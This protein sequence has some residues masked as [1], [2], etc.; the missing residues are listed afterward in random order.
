MGKDRR[1]FHTEL[2]EDFLPPLPNSYIH[3][4]MKSKGK[5]KITEYLSKLRHQKHKRIC[6]PFPRWRLKR[7]Q[8]LEQSFPHVVMVFLLQNNVTKI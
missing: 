6:V 4:Q 5:D 3:P 1:I 8:A 2:E 7:Y